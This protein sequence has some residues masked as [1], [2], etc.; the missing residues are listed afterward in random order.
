MP[1]GQHR[2]KWSREAATGRPGPSGKGDKLPFSSLAV[3]LSVS[4][5]LC[6]SASLSVF[7]SPPRP[8]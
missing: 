3:S 5:S 4:H 2:S 1:A 8:I 7:L 6:L